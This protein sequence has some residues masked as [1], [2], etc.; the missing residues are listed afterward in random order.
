MLIF[1][2][3]IKHI[4]YKTNEFK[5]ELFHKKLSQFQ[6]GENRF[7]LFPTVHLLFTFDVHFYVYVSYIILPISILTLFEPILLIAYP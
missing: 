7:Q 4:V 3:K 6:Y 2:I 5:S 1:Y